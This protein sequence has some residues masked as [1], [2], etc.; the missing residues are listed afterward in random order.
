MQQEYFT[1]T[2]PSATAMQA[3]TSSGKSSAAL[4]VELRL[5]A[6]KMTCG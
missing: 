1:M 6:S 5:G 4:M 2:H 3:K